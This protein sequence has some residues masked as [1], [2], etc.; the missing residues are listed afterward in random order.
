MAKSFVFAKRPIP[1]VEDE[2][3]YAYDARNTQLK[4]AITHPE[5]AYCVAPGVDYQEDYRPRQLDQVAIETLEI[6]EKSARR[7]SGR[8]PRVHELIVAA[9]HSV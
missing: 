4:C 6:V 9:L 8:A 1:I 2:P 7:L 5:E 3:R